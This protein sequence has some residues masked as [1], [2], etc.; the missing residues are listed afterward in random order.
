MAKIATGVKPASSRVRS[1]LCRIATGEP[2]AWEASAA[3]FLTEGEL[4][5]WQRYRHLPS[6]RMF[7]AGRLLL[8]A[9]Y[10]QRLDRPPLE[11]PLQLTTKGKPWLADVPGSFS[12]SHSHGWVLLV[13]SEQ[14]QLGADLEQ[15]TANRDLAGLAGM[16]MAERELE[17]F[18][19]LPAQAQ[20][21]WFFRVW[22]AKE[23]LVKQLGTGIGHGLQKIS[24]N[25]ELTGFEAPYERYVLVPLEASCGFRASAVCTGDSALELVVEQHRFEC[26]GECIGTDGRLREQY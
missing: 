12:L 14:L 16:V 26:L 23:A 4:T 19:A 5:R 18:N 2:D 6:R 22:T 15:V 21:D 20:P 8:R 7:F 13:W 11:V 9:V 1:I 10:G 17:R 24:L 25:A 3:H